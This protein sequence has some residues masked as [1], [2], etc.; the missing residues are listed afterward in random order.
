MY[1]MAY[2]CKCIYRK[3]NPQE[4]LYCSIYVRASPSNVFV[5]H[6]D[7]LLANDGKYSSSRHTTSRGPSGDPQGN[8]TKTD[9]LMEKLFFRSNSLCITYPFL[10]FKV[11]KNIQKY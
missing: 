2:I 6:L 7:V 10:F 1:N 3:Q 9:D 8:N 4:E 5:F 11:R